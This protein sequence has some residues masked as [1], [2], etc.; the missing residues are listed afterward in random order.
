MIQNG[1]GVCAT[2]VMCA[3]AVA[4]PPFTI[5]VL[6][7]EGDSVA[8]VGSITRI[9][10]LAVNNKGQWLVEADTDHPDSDA[11][12][13]MIK[14]G[15]LFLREGDPIDVPTG[16]AINGF[17]SVNLNLDGHSGWNIFLQD[18]GNISTDSGIFYDDVLVFQESTISESPDFGKDTPYIGFFDTRFNDADQILIMA[19]VDDPDIPTGVDRALVVVDYDANTGTYTET[20]LA[21]EGDVLPGQVE[22]VADFGTDPD[23]FD[24]NNKGDVIYIADLTG[25]TATDMAIYLNEALLAQEGS[26][27]PVDG[28]NWSS[29]GSS[30][31]TINNKG[32]YAYRGSLDGNAADNLVVIANGALFVQEGDLGPDGEPFISFGSSPQLTDASEAVWVATWDDANGD[33][34][35]GL[36]LGNDVIV[37]T[38]VTQIDGVTVADL[39][40]G[41][42]NFFVSDNGNAI[43]FEATLANGLE[44]A[45]LISFCAADF[46]RDGSL[47]ILDFVAMQNA[48]TTGCP[49]ADINN[50]GDA[51]ILDFVAFQNIFQTGCN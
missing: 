20:V 2:L 27:S 38:G 21:K 7:L 5:D 23:E 8:G 42:D 18:T 49:R 46:N 39:A 43:I 4:A 15:A 12:S 16:G 33:P 11:D 3:G 36:F 37:Q 6:V 25:D 31:V 32:D 26:P 24:F 1:S 9:D 45:F 22:S 35:E 40:T 29:L 10:N 17:D 51:N 28:R 14:D 47:S 30:T 19:S 13:V 34:V 41:Q 50:D 48:F 44:G